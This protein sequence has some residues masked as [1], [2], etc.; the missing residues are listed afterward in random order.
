MKRFIKDVDVEGKRVLLRLDLNVPLDESGHITDM[1]R[2]MESMSTIN[3]L[4]DHHAKVIICSHLGRPK[5]EINLKYSLRPVAEAMAKLSKYSVSFCPVTIGEEAKRMV[6]EMKDGDIVILENVRFDA[7]EEANDETFAKGLASLADIYCLDAFGTAHRKHASTYAVADLLPS[8]VGFLVNK[9][10]KSVENILCHPSRPLVAI[11]GGSKVEDK[12]PVIENL[13]DIADVILIGGA[14]SF[15]FIK[16][17]GGNVGNSIVDEARID[18]VKKWLNMAKDKNVQ[19]VLPLD[20]VCNHSLDSEDKPVTMPAGDIKEG[21]M[22]LDIGKK[23]IKLFKKYIKKA[24]SIV[25]NGPMGVFEKEEYSLG[26]KKMAKFASKSRAFTFV[27]G[28]DSVSAVIA[29]RCSKKINHLST[30]GGASLTLLGGKSLVC[31]DHINEATD[32]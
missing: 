11:L 10:L 24:G 2:I 15:T 29:L 20:Y 31:I 7:R 18:D 14:M 16:A 9:E 1:T 5:G 3:Y 13:M 32:E 25:W 17:S 23:T 4:C 6:D 27:G 19:I 21:Y 26:T 8:C 12:L 28:G 30:G 22:G